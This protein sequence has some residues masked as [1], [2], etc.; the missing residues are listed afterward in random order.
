[1]TANGLAAGRAT[2]RATGICSPASGRVWDTEVWEY[3]RSVL[4][5]VWQVREVRGKFGKFGGSLA[6]SEEQE[7]LCRKESVTCL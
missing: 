5:E 6:S 2:G 1:M 7:L 3:R 4:W